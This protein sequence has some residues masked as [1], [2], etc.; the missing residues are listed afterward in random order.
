[1]QNLIELYEIVSL[2]DAALRDSERQ[3]ILNA[4]I[5]LRMFERAMESFKSTSAE[6]PAAA[7][8]CFPLAA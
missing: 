4:R 5:C 8:S 6:A 1:M 2:N 3:A 7:E